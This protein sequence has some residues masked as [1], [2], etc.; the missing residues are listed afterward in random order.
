[1]SVAFGA[2]QGKVRI[3][4]QL[5]VVGRLSRQQ[6]DAHACRDVDQMALYQI[7]AA[8]QID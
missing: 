1:M 7:G 4:Q 2:M 6:D 3:L 8:D 5:I